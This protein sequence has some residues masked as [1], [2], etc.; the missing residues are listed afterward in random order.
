MDNEIIPKGDMNCQVDLVKAHFT[1]LR[2]LHP[3]N[4]IVLICEA[5][6]E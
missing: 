3:K 5:N 2:A 1:K 6:S 4:P